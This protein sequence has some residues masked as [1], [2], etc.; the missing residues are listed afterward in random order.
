MGTPKVFESEYKFCS[1]LWENEPV[2]SME[3]VK[4][5]KERLGWS[6]SNTYRVIRRLAE[7]GIIKNENAVVSALVTKQQVQVAEIEE[8]M[9]TRFDGDVPAFLAAFTK[10]KSLSDK[11]IEEIM[12]IIDSVKE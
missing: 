4:L 5:C 8:L 3:L 7:R 2:G 10:Q 1:I 11:Q 12:K 9:E 6:K